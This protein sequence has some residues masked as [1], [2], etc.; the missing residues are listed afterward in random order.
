M[1]PNNELTLLSSISRA[2]VIQQQQQQQQ[3]QHT[4]QQLLLNPHGKFH[5]FL[6]F[7]KQ[8]RHVTLH[9]TLIS[10]VSHTLRT[11]CSQSYAIISIGKS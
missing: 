11:R 2:V 1:L 10:S 7:L 4:P 8:S 9:L 5:D 3:Q 6:D